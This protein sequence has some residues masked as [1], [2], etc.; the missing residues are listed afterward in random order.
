MAEGFIMTEYKNS[1]Y[2]PRGTIDVEINHPYFG[3][4]TFTASPDD[5]EPHGRQ[6]FA[7]LKDEAAPYVAP[8]V[9][10]GSND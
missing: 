1:H 2:N 5:I 4:I 6:I 3:W 8:E 10:D 7:D 9:S